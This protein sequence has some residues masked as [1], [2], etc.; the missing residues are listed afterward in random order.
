MI[1]TT[2][3]EY[4]KLEDKTIRCQPLARSAE[5]RAVGVR[6]FAAVKPEFGV[7]VCV[8]VCGW[9][10]ALVAFAQDQC[11]VKR[12]LL[13]WMADLVLAR[14]L[15]SLASEN[16]CTV[17]NLAICYQVWC[18]LAFVFFPSIFDFVLFGLLLIVV[19]PP[20]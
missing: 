14:N 9:Q 6:L 4:I 2:T 19:E 5:D 17:P 10:R 11:E 8:C 12:G 15:A 7:C 20:T 16:G 18:W 1:H 13:G 3:R